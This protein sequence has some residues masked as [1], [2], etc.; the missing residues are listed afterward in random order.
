MGYLVDT[1]VVI[2]HLGDDPAT[3]QL[4]DQLSASRLHISI[5]TY[6]ET[7]QGLLRSPDIA[8][9]QT[10]FADLLD[11]IAV[12]PLDEDVA[13]RCAQLRE[14]LMRQGKRIRPRALDL[15]YC[16]YGLLQRRHWNTV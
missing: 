15:N 6:L 9:A 16:S 3:V 13:R 11:G 8:I 12:L 4:L 5:I 2:D 14:D 7:Y 10:R 1:D